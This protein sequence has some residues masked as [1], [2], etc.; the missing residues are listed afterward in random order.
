MAIT[1]FRGKYFC[2]SNMHPLENWIESAQGI[3]VPTSEHDYMTR[4]LVNPY[5]QRE[6]ALARGDIDDSRVYKDGLAAKN[7]AHRYIEEGAIQ[8]DDWEV[9]CLGVMTEAVDKKFT[10][11]VAIAQILYDTGDEEIIEGNTWGDKF[12]GVDPPGSD[13]GLNHLGKILMSVR[14]SLDI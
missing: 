4:R 11:N 9:A 10:A 14:S 1:R 7:L 13:N 3:F 12:W 8:L 2:F 5:L 6:V